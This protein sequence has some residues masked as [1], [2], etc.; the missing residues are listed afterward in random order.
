[1][2]FFTAG[3]IVI[4]GGSSSA[5]SSGNRVPQWVNNATYSDGQFVTFNG[6]MYVAIGTPGVGLVPPLEVATPQIPG[7]PKWSIAVR[8]RTQAVPWDDTATYYADQVVT[9]LGGTYILDGA[10]V[11]A[12]TKPT[13]DKKWLRL[14]ET[15]TDAEGEKVTS[16]D[17]SSIANGCVISIFGNADEDARVAHHWVR[18]T[19]V[20]PF[21][22]GVTLYVLKFPRP[23]KSQARPAITMQTNDYNSAFMIV[24]VAP[25]VS[26][27][28]C[29]GYTVLVNNAAQVG[30]ADFLVTVKEAI[31]QVSLP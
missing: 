23:I 16:A 19:V 6:S 12:G 2:S 4:G 5:P 14:S 17:L 28:E 18:V 20:A 10:T 30:T 13:R 15:L 21:G 25:L 29:T 9:Y 3:D 1:M 7:Q 26:G 11:P 31:D 27:S 8:G 22:G 24:S